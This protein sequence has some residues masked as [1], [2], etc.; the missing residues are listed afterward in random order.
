MS[1]GSRLT[2]AVV[3]CVCAFAVA[4]SLAPAAGAQAGVIDLAITKTDSPDPVVEGDQ[5][6]YTITATNN[7]SLLTA[8]G[9]KVVDTLPGSVDFVSAPGCTKAGQTL[10]CA[11]GSLDPQ[12]SKVFTVTVIPRTPGVITNTASVSGDQVDVSQGNNSDAEATIVEARTPDLAITKIDDPDPVEI[13]GNITYTLT[14]SNVTNIA[15]GVD[16]A[17]G[18]TVTDTLPAGVTFVSASSGCTHASG[19]VTCQIGALAEGASVDRQIVVKAP[20]QETVLTNF[21][22]ITGNQTDPVSSNNSAMASTSVIRSTPNLQ[23]TKTDSADPVAENEDLVY[24]ITVNNLV[25]ASDGT[26]NATGV[27]VVD[28][29][30]AGVTFRSASQGCTVAAGD[31]TCSLGAIAEG[32]SKQVTVTV[33]AKDPG[34]IRNFASVSA[35]QDDPVSANDDAAESTTVVAALPN[36]SINKTDSPDPV[37]AGEQLTYTFAVSNVAN[38]ADGVDNA[39]NVHVTDVLPNGVTYVSGDA[40]CSNASGTV[41]CNFGDL[42]EGQSASKQIV[43]IVSSPGSIS[44]TATVDGDES[45]ASTSNDSDTEVTTVDAAQPDLSISKAD[46]P[47][48]VGVNDNL[49]YTLTA[50]NVTNAADGIDNATGVTITDTLP[51]SVD[52]VSASNSCSNASGT[53]TCQV[54]PLAEGASVQRSIVVR[55]R[56][57]GPI[58]NTASIAGNQTDPV[59]GNNSD[60]ETTTVEP[61]TPDLSLTKDDSADP[62][63]E[64]DDLVYTLTATNET[65][66]ANGTDNATGVT[67][68]DTLPASVTFKRA[69]SGC[70]NTSG[71]VTCLLG[72]LDEGQSKQVTVT[73]RPRTPGQITN[74]ATVDGQELDPVPANDDATE[75]T[76]VGVS[77]PNLAA[78]KTAPAGPFV[79]G[80]QITYSLSVMNVADA[81]D[82][83]D[84]ATGV[85]IVDVL[86]AG[87]SFV[88]ASNGCLNAG[89]TV[90]CTA[91]ELDE[92]QSAQFQVVVQATQEGQIS[93][94]ATAGGGES[95]PATGDD[96]SSVV[97]TVGAAPLAKKC[98]RKMATIVIAAPGLV[99]T[100]TEGK[101]VILGTKG[102]DKIFSLGGN[103]LICALK[104]K[105]KVRSG[106]G[107][108]RVILSKGRDK[109]NGGPGKDKLR[110]G[111]G[112]DRVR[113]KGGADRLGGSAGNDKLKGGLGFDFCNGGPGLN[114][115]KQCES[116]PGVSLP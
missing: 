40:G 17:S 15:D 30:P 25:D 99:T 88:S 35:D 66:A 76:T 2:A 43:V 38:A 60:M 5:L 83:V 89:G 73:V 95:D 45:D 113:G 53:V 11:V 67:V 93:N 47:D 81:T 110:G 75:Q 33:R 104:G 69:S 94:T 39:T 112:N 21:A 92:G 80:D 18:V 56:Q 71:T 48:P 87:V 55:P 49:T 10:S 9:V 36:L 114:V 8:T 70:S 19:T 100:G 13:N 85:S 57:V 59:P 27:T 61:S 102:R 96:S 12:A 72:A 68:V 31:V 101:D 14:A 111:K 23:I 98:K 3:A 105:D 24:T 108:D 6:V 7:S 97:V 82:G 52:F 20:G 58:S 44:N 29:L 42:D 91:D 63:A 62:I 22:A 26:D 86:P 74:F 50:S 79:V 46:S 106:K 115:L 103:D 1:I 28:D 54:G 4:L 37:T 116:G 90:T 64:N 65:N 84:N 77:N 109:V 51:G 34:T 32:S 16:N 41:T 78:S 107:R